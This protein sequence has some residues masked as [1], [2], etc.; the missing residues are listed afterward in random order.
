MNLK[1][2]FSISAAVFTG[3]LTFQFVEDNWDELSAKFSRVANN[4]AESATKKQ[5]VYC[6]AV[7]D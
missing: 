3:V 7:D 4:F 2:A 6:E 1:E 5:G